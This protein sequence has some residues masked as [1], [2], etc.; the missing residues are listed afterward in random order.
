MKH[1]RY[2]YGHKGLITMHY[3]HL[4]SVYHTLAIL[5]LV[6]D[7]VPLVAASLVCVCFQWES[8]SMAA[9]MVAIKNQF[10]LVQLLDIVLA[11]D[12]SIMKTQNYSEY[13]TARRKINT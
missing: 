4:T 5:L 2:S 11:N 8:C 10:L 6:A 3:M 1:S 13:T 12:T 9:E 7:H